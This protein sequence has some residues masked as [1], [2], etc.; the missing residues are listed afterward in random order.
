MSHGSLRYK[1]EWFAPCWIGRW[2]RAYCLKEDINA[3]ALPLSVQLLFGREECRL[4]LPGLLQQQ[5]VG[6]SVHAWR[7]LACSSTFNATAGYLEKSVE[8][9]VASLLSSIIERRVTNACI[10]TRW[11]VATKACTMSPAPRRFRILHL[12]VRALMRWFETPR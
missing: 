5:S 12:F 2:S 1:G 9:T 7:P 11:S 4:E 10:P 6:G 8:S 3:Y